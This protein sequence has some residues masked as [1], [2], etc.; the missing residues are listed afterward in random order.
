V[1]R[2]SL[3]ECIKNFKKALSSDG[4]NAKEVKADDVNDMG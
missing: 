3:G 4:Q 1:A 2:K